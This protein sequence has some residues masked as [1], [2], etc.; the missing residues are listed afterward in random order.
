M[1][2]KDC[3]SF[4]LFSFVAI[5]GL[6]GGAAWFVYKEEKPHHDPPNFLSGLDD[7]YGY[8]GKINNIVDFDLK[9][10]NH[11]I[12]LDYTGSGLYRT[13]QIRNIFHQYENTLY[14]NPHSFSPSSRITTEYVEEARELVLKFL[15]T[16]ASE[17]SVIFT[18]SATASLRLLAESFP[19]SSNSL[20]L[21]TRDN[22]N[23]VLGI[24]RWA[25]HYGA[26]FRM[27]EA[28]ELEE[29]GNRKRAGSSSKINHLFAYPPEENESRSASLTLHK[30][31]TQSIS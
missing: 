28:S 25:T 29:K 19:W 23:S 31:T 15:G 22:H 9:H 2:S 21:Y 17:Y 24:R 13:S 11:S 7:Y 26:K 8:D 18:A 14:S 1:P 27:V 20:Y 30:E 5:I 4:L 12:Y 3:I 6:A 16:T 10:L